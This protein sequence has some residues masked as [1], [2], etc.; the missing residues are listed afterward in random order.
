[1]DELNKYEQ[2]STKTPLWI[3]LVVIGVFIIIVILALIFP[4]KPPEIRKKAADAGIASSVT[5]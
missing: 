3:P 5:P 1:M 2:E 4:G